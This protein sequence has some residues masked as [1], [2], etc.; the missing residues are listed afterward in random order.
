MHVD[1]LV[2]TGEMYLKAV[3]ELEEEGVVA[4]RAR[5][6][7][8]FEHG[9]ST[10]SETVQRLQRHGLV[11]L[12]ADR[13]VGLTAAG[14]RMAGSVMRKHR[15]AEVFLGDVVGLDWELLHEEAC[16][17]EHVMSDR[18][19]QLM[20]RLLGHPARTPY[21]NLIHDADGESRAASVGALNLVGLVR[22][23]GGSVIARIEWI[24]EP[25]QAD[26]EAL[27]S[28]RRTGLVPGAV[29]TAHAHGALLLLRPAV[30]E[31]EE[32]ER[33]EVEAPDELAV[34]LFAVPVPGLS[35]PV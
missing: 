11:E 3:L 20:D 22:E 32:G 1:D 9:A 7:E 8:R 17:W 5:L 13:H 12:E 28:L 6:V 34:H 10:V 33:P 19:A 25:L 14:R 15:L 24:G 29:V 18:A 31:G 23:H 21:G 16:R 30:A 27:A 35:E 26:P 4:M 2:D